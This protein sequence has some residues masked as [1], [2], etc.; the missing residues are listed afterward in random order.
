MTK[1]IGR[2]RKIQVSVDSSPDDVALANLIDKSKRAKAMCMPALKSFYLVE[3]L[4]LADATEQEIQTT[5]IE[6]IH[7]LLG[8]IEI[9]KRLSGIDLTEATSHKTGRRSNKKPLTP[10]NNE[11]SNPSLEDFEI[12]IDDEEF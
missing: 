8:R 4:L 7:T 2:G 1:E 3:A 6:S 5:A 9:I 12:E 11:T 10:N